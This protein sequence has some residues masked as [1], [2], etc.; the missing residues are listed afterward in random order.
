MAERE[1]ALAGHYQPGV[2]GAGDGSA[3][4][5]QELCGLDLDQVAAWPDTAD[6][7]AA[8]IAARTGCAVP[9]GNGGSTAAGDLRVLWNGP[10]RWWVVCPIGGPALSLLDAFDA[11]QAAVSDLSQSRTVLRLGGPTSRAVLAKGL[12]VDLH[13]RAF[14]A[15]RVA[16]S[17][18]PHTGV[19]VHRIDD[20]DS[21]DLYVFRG[22]GLSFWQWL[23]DAAAEY[24]YT[25]AE[26][27]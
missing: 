16:Q 4:T 9:E 25:V 23:T 24:G 7:V 5:I 22:F 2:H 14:A 12:P 20:S 13:R 18:I 19:L 3:I 6:R 10:D 17:A 27:G 15:G 26:R 21:F 8:T 1:S 11:D